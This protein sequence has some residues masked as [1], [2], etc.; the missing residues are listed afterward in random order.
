M[1]FALP[2]GER[3]PTMKKLA[4]LALAGLIMASVAPTFSMAP[5]VNDQSLCNKNHAQCREYVFGLDDPWY[6]IMVLL[7]ACDIAFGKC[8]LGL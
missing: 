1:P 4:L 6:K 2:E 8:M 7:T 5:D 3:R